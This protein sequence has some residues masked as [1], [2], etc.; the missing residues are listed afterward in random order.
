MTTE[1]ALGRAPKNPSET[2]NNVRSAEELRLIA[3]SLAQN[4]E[5]IS[6][7]ETLVSGV[8]GVA[9]RYIDSDTIIPPA[10]DLGRYVR[11]RRTQSRY[12]VEVA[13][14]AEIPERF[15]KAL[16]GQCLTLFVKTGRRI[17]NLNVDEFLN[18]VDSS[19]LQVPFYFG[20][21]IA[22]D[23]TVAVWEA[24]SG[25]HRA[26]RD[27]SPELGSALMRAIAEINALPAAD[28][29]STLSSETR[30]VLAPIDYYEEIYRQQMTEAQREKWSAA[31]ADTSALVDESSGLADRVRSL[32]SG[33]LTHNDINPNNVLFDSSGRATLIDW[34]GAALGF[35]GADLRFLQ[36][37]NNREALLDCYV[38]HANTLGLNLRREDVLA[39]YRIAEGMRKVY[40]GWGVM[41][42][43][44]VLN[45]LALVN[46]VLDKRPSN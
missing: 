42:L 36:K 35:A 29:A 23:Q 20:S 18:R 9:V 45:G 39:G 27:L 19:D 13:G 46:S 25:E 16:Q 2:A 34:E 24:V 15:A 30:W 37:L 3:S 33:L 11:S 21:F 38:D 1:T 4:P 26:F 22:G 28:L 32:G 8:L 10:A 6:R 43:S 17:R 14:G 44:P 12:R 40:R 41:S 31:F 7:F 5:V